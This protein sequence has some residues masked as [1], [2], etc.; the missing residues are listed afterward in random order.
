MSGTARRAV[1]TPQRGVPTC[2]DHCQNAMSLDRARE[3]G[4]GYPYE[5]EASIFDDYV[6]RCRPGIG[7]GNAWPPARIQTFVGDVCRPLVCARPESGA[8][9]RFAAGGRFQPAGLG[10]HSRVEPRPIRVP[11][12]RW[13]ELQLATGTGLGW[14]QDLATGKGSG[15]GT[16]GIEMFPAKRGTGQPAI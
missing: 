6:A 14:T 8:Q 13:Q 5:K 9:T 10:H 4:R 15:S 7:P 2:Y 3:P 16:L 11:R 12:P 1:R